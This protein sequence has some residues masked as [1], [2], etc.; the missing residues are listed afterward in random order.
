MFHNTE[1]YIKNYLKG[2]LVNALRHEKPP[3]EGSTIPKFAYSASYTRQSVE[4]L[5]GSKRYLVILDCSCF[6]TT[7]KVQLVDILI[8]R[9]GPYVNVCL[10]RPNYLPADNIY[11]D[12]GW[13]VYKTTGWKHY[14]K[15][16]NTMFH[17]SRCKKGFR[18]II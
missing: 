14:A 10:I 13:E 3:G 11:Y 17:C 18:V 5:E 9:R 1:Y 7:D 15:K 2:M 6:S 4:V 8:T 12:C 16:G